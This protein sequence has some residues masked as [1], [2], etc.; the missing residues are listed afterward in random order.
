MKT[1]ISIP[2]DLYEQAEKFAKAHK[3]SRSELYRD[4]LTRL[5]A[6]NS[7]EEITRQLNEVYSTEDSRLPAAIVQMQTQTIRARNEPW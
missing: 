4:A 3:M 5:L 2:D 7:D 1:A 6:S